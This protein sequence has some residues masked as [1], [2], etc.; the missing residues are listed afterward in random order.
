M[1]TNSTCRAQV[2]K[3]RGAP[4]DSDVAERFR[5]VT[6]RMAPILTDAAS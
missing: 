3:H 2:K 6:A 4:E 5:C 1:T